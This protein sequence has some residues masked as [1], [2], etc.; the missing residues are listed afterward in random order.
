MEP[1]P[2]ATTTELLPMAAEAQQAVV[3][4][5]LQQL[6]TAVEPQPAAAKTVAVAAPPT[7]PAPAVADS[8]RAVVVEIPDD[9]VRR[10]AGTSR[11]ARLCQPPRPRRGRS[12]PEATSAWRWGAQRTVSGPCRRALDPQRVWSRGGAC[13]RPA[14]PLR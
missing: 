14:G 7:S 9:N 3:V 8:P 10:Q 13:R 6:A 5:E 1:Q 12:W 11:R 2:A 4:A